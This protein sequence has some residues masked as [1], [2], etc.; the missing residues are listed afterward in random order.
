MSSCSL[1][2]PISC[3][4]GLAPSGTGSV[5]LVHEKEDSV[6]KFVVLQS[7]KA[8]FPISLTSSLRGGLRNPISSAKMHC[9]FLKAHIRWLPL[10]VR[11]NLVALLSGPEVALHQYH[12]SSLSCVL[13][14]LTIPS[15]GSYRELYGVCL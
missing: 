4:A 10:I 14:I 15:K 1:L 9:R 11:Y 8:T 5:P 3:T 7:S 12:P 6:L 2:T 13:V